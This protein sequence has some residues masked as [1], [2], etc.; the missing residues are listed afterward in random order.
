MGMRPVAQPSSIMLRSIFDMMKASPRLQDTHLHSSTPSSAASTSFWTSSASPPSPSSCT[1]AAA[2]GIAT[3][4]PS[5]FSGFM[6]CLPL[7]SSPSAAETIVTIVWIGNF[8]V[9][10]GDWRQLATD[11]RWDEEQEKRE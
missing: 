4:T 3:G 1:A 7:W 6:G 10:F 8:F 5:P 11:N 9:G 2:M